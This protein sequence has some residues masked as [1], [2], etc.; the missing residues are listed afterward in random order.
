M[1]RIHWTRTAFLIL[2]MVAGL[3]LAVYAADDGEDDTAEAVYAAD[4]GEAATVENDRYRLSASHVIDIYD[5]VMEGAGAAEAKAEAGSGQAEAA[6]SGDEIPDGV[7]RVYALPVGTALTLTAAKEGL[8]QSITTYGEDNLPGETFSMTESGKKSTEALALAVGQK[9]QYTVTE[10]DAEQAFLVLTLS[11]PTGGPE[12]N[13]YFRVDAAQDVYA[14]AQ[15]VRERVLARP[16]TATV[17]VNGV[18]QDFQA[19]NIDGSN[20]F[21][22]RDLALA[23]QNAGQGFEIN[24]REDIQAII[25]STGAAYTAVGGELAA[26]TGETAI[27]A[28][29]NAKLYVDGVRHYLVAYNIDGNNYFKLREIGELAGF[30]VDW[31]PAEKRILIDTVM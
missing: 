6:E 9:V 25:L 3:S 1:K 28:S 15:P 18:Q 29:R 16:T 14:P 31:D 20:Y 23:L 26:E 5:I 30:S 2:V 7:I 22:L 10:L 8:V 24:W 13:Y 19:Y 21:K 4:S 12:E 11:G 17:L 27:V